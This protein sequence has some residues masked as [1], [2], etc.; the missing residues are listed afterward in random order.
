MGVMTPMNAESSR[1]NDD[2][3]DEFARNVDKRFDKVDE[4]FDR[5]DQEL[6]RIN[7]R[8]DDLIKVA[9]AGSITLIGVLLAGI[10][11]LIALVLTQL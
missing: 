10:F 11:S 9:I 2:R 8:L 5:V 6:A 3:L 4:R 1:W 7:G